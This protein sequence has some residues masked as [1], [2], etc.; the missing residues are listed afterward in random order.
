M[1]KGRDFIFTGLQPWDLSIGSNARD[2][3]LEVSKHNRVLYINSPLSMLSNDLK[4]N[5]IDVKH[6]QE[7]LNHKAAPLRSVNKNLYLLDFQFTIF[8]VNSLPDGAIFDFIN[9]IN[10][11]KIFKCINKTLSQLNFQNTIH[12]CDNDIYRSFYAKKYIAAKM[13]IY[14]R[15]DN[16]LCID[17]WKRH[18]LRLEPLIIAK[19][20]LVVCNSAELASFANKYNPK[21]FDIG[22][23][24][25]LTAYKISNETTPNDISQIPHPIIGYIGHITSLRL[26]PDL[27]YN[28]AKDNP[29][30]SLVMVGKID[31]VFA[32]HKMNELSN[33]YFLGS[34]PPQTVPDYINAFD[35]CINPQALN[36]LTIG[37]YPRK[38]DEYLSLGKPTIATKTDTMRMFEKYVYLCSTKE[39]YQSAIDHILSTK[40][41]KQPVETLVAYANQH[42]WQNSVESL[43]DVIT[44][45]E[46]GLI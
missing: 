9:R 8:P 31:D 37:N 7:V 1:I 6:R 22:Q 2:I 32:Q 38:I 5:N 18:A 23:G 42:T 33:V 27:I 26:D 45:Y 21:T 35:I 28:I 46:K 11:R 16:M 30:C 14:Y 17:F 39:E 20:D 29:H 13:S 19:S 44:R 12:F 25:D 3:A 34:K 36:E 10:N 15:R 43:Y 4:S 40:E 41:S 24:V